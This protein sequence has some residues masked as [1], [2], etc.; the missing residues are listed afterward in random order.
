MSK[1]KSNHRKNII[2]FQKVHIK[3]QHIR[4]LFFLRLYIFDGT[5]ILRYDKIKQ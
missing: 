1:G 2:M 3:C 5:L 4:I